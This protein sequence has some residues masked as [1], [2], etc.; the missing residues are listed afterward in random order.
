MRLYTVSSSNASE[1]A[2]FSGADIGSQLLRFPGREEES[3][4]RDHALKLYDPAAWS[5]RPRLRVFGAEGDRR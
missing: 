3:A 1:D 4:G 5:E 2:S